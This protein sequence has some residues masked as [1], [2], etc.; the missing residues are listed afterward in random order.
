VLRCDL[1]GPVLG[2][3]IEL[4]VVVGVRI[5]VA[6][7]AAPGSHGGGV[8]NHWFLGLLGLSRAGSN[9]GGGIVSCGVRGLRGLRGLCDLRGACGIGV[10]VLGGGAEGFEFGLFFFGAVALADFGIDKP[11]QTD[12]S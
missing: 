10:V 5:A 9:S 8:S 1:L 7:T 3:L 6:G 12:G 4:R 11:A 2:A